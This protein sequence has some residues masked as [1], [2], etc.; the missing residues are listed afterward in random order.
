MSPLD[1]EKRRWLDENG[2][3]LLRGAIPSGS[4]SP[5][6][7]AFEAGVLPS[8]QWPVP[9]GRDWRHSLLDLDSTVQEVCRLAILL[10]AAHHIIGR[11]FFLAQVEGRE[12]RVGGNEQNLHRDGFDGR[13]PQTAHAL[14]FLDSFGPENGATQVVPGTHRSDGL[15][16]SADQKHPQATVVEGEA[17]D[18]LLFG[19]NLLH[20]ATCNRS[21]AARRSLLIT[22]A[23]LALQSDY[24]MTRTLRAVRMNTDQVFDL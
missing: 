17:G 9:R 7:A 16:A 8:D 1:A 21:G 13:H 23:S 24:Q 5:L 18:I 20:G 2:Y 11:P 19:P 6:R 12:P 10:A 4:V 22:Y 3:L 14:A 15:E